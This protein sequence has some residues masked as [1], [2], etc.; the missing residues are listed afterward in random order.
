MDGVWRGKRRAGVSSKKRHWDGGDVEKC[1]VQVRNLL[2]I[3]FLLSICG[4]GMRC[5]G[6]GAVPCSPAP[7]SRR[8]A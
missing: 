6:M 7:W 5:S 1:C 8:M 2:F 3:H 4:A